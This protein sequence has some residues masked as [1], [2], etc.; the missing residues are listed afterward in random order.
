MAE[1][2]RTQRERDMVLAPNE[3]MLVRDQTKGNVDV[4][5]GPCKTG[6]SG[7]DQPVIFNEK[8]KKFQNVALNEAIQTFMTA[9]E[10]F[11]IVLKNPAQANKH[12]S[13]QGKITNAELDIGRKVN[14]PGPVSFALWPGQM[15][16]VLKGH[17]LR[18]NQYLLVR[19]Y[20]EDAARKNWKSAIIKPQAPS[21][22]TQTQADAESI[23]TTGEMPDLTM[24]KLLVIKGTDVAFYIPPT[25]VEVVPDEKGALVREAVTLERLEY[26][27]LRDQNG[28]K[29]YERG[30]AVVF[31]EPTEVFS[32]REIERDGKV[33]Q[34]R[35]FRAIE[36]NENSGIYIKV[37]ADYEEDDKSYKVGDELFITGKDQMIYFPREE[38][39]IVK[40]DS[41][42]IHYGIAI[43]SGEARYVLDRNKGEIALVKGPTI[44]LPD[45]R[46]Q[47]I[48]RRLLDFKTCSMLYPGNN[49]AIEHNA[50][51]AGVDVPTYMSSSAVLAEAAAAMLMATPGQVP[52]A[53]MGTM[54]YAATPGG[55]AGLAAMP[56]VYAANALIGDS[57]QAR[58]LGNAPARGFS[59]DEFKR[60]TQYTEPRAITLSTKFD[61]AVSIDIWPGYAIMLVRKSGERR[62]EVGPKTV[63][64][65]YDETPQVMTLSRGKPKNMDNPLRTV[66]LLTNA[67]KV[68]DIIQVE[69]KDFC[70]LQ[71]KVSYRV[72]FEGDDP[73]KWFGVENYVKFLCD[74]MRSKLRNA[75]KKFGVEEFYSHSEAIVRDIVVGTAVDPVNGKLK[76][77]PGTVF[78]EN[79][80]R[81]YDVEILETNLENQDIAKMLVSAQREV[82]NHT[83]T[84]AADRR[85]LEFVR[86]S[87]TIK[88]HMA[89]IQTL[90]AQKSYALKQ[91]E[92]KSKLDHDMAL[93]ASNAKTAAEQARVQL[94]TERAR[95][96][97]TNVT[98]GIQRAATEQ[99]I[100]MEQKKL[101]QR[102]LW[103]EAEVQ[104]VVEKAKAVSPDL[105][106]ALNAFGERAMVET[107]AKSMAPLSILGGESVA[108]ILAKLLAGTEIAKHLLPKKE[109][110][111][112]K[113]KQPQA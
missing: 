106:A 50:R 71:V 83:L 82:I 105:V 97:V 16:K 65:D 70:R 5:V 41:N 76:E 37:I 12:P 81:I 91:E 63:L 86:E 85:K 33:I 104:A 59:G 69:T 87:E 38:H 72:N 31:P 24:G 19:V 29:R 90:T 55:S 84:L 100:A 6:L 101:E 58:G 78:Q 64:L 96:E 89:E 11:Y 88:Q 49:A 94:E 47:V 18:S 23:V 39:A 73:T 95:G 80:M 62:V 8:T 74:H 92:L 46:H 99:E 79:G 103:L 22:E 4:F 109:D 51:I 93:I 20:D 35:K 68:S 36:L 44:F 66:Y 56:G 3:W 10:G 107:V 77:R 110:G 25:G 75:V 14:I 26:C 9:P 43:P 111:N 42:E 48:V 108:E 27:L 52:A 112:G 32:E 113:T 13:G 7:T 15:A 54:A 61:G 45:P 40:Y 60:R 98:L 53:V 57:A 30:P 1:E 2:E 21:S 102:K 17:H 34:T 67:N 28:N